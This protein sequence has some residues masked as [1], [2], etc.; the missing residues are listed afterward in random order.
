MW[1]LIMKLPYTE[2]KFFPEVKSQT[3]VHF[4]SHV[5]VLLTNHLTNIRTKLCASCISPV[6]SQHNNI[7]ATLHKALL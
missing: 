5:N 2:V 7:K 4:E 6:Q 3:G 1:T